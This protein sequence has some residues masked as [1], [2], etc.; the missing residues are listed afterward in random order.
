MGSP[1]IKAFFI[2]MRR[3]LIVTAAVAFII[4]CDNIADSNSTAWTF[5]A[6]RVI[7]YLSPHALASLFHLS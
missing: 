4:S 3:Y 7:D 5:K 1:N 6:Y 2:F